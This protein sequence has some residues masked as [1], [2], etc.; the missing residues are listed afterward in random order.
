[1]FSHP[2][3]YRCFILLRATQCCTR[4][5][6]CTA[7]CL[8]WLLVLCLYGGYLLGKFLEYRAVCFPCSSVSPYQSVHSCSHSLTCLF[9]NSFNPKACVLLPITS[10]SW[11][12]SSQHSVFTRDVI[13]QTNICSATVKGLCMDSLL[14]TLTTCKLPISWEVLNSPGKNVPQCV[15]PGASR[16]PAFPSHPTPI[17]WP[18]LRESLPED[19]IPS[20][21]WVGERSHASQPVGKY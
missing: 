7:I 2:C 4:Y 18:L 15:S 19:F 10:S 13:L 5:Q 20:A 9:T 16:D 17:P 8:I 3:V 11:L 12:L 14:C 6:G 1:M 21:R